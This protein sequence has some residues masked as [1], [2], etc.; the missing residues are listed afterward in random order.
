MGANASADAKKAK[1]SEYSKIL[2]EQVAGSLFKKYDAN[3]DKSLSKG[4]VKKLLAQEFGLDEK[5]IVIAECAMDAD[6]NGAVD[7]KEFNAILKDENL[8][9]VICDTESCHFLTE[10]WKIFRKY[11]KDASGN[12]TK[13][14]LKA[15][16]KSLGIPEANADR[17]VADADANKNALINFNEFIHWLP[18]TAVLL[19]QNKA[20]K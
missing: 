3:A 12:L 17:I 19:N 8:V 9:R 14:E 4:E 11:D 13:I 15:L 10:A 5:Q 6:L 2:R 1:Q 16:L 18:A 20:K 7:V